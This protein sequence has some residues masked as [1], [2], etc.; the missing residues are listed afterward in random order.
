MA[1]PSLEEF[2]KDNGGRQARRWC[3]D[4]PDDVKAQ[5]LS[6]DA[7]TAV[8]VRWLLSLGHDE[9]SYGKVDTWRR[10]ERERQAQ[11]E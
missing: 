2:A 5:I 10:S 7:S 11:P 6:S 9:A 3:D 4:L 1:R 8:V